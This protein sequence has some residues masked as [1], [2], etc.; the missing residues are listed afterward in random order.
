MVKWLWLI[1]FYLNVPICIILHIIKS[2]GD[3]FFAYIGINKFEKAALLYRLYCITR[4]LCVNVK[5]YFG[6]LL[7]NTRVKLD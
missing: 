7:N 1:L 6:S 3:Y 2:M 5:Y 4:T